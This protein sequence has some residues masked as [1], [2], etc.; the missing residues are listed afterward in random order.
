MRLG[1]ADFGDPLRQGVS[2]PGLTGEIGADDDFG[3]VGVMD[4]VEVSEE[5]KRAELERAAVHDGD[6]VVFNLE[7]GGAG[8]TWR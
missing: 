7:E 2:V 1:P 3:Q 5:A 4:R 8:A 6:R